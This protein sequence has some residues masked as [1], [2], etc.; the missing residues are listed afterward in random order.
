MDEEW[1]DVPQFEGMYAVSSRGR[2]RSLPRHSGARPSPV[3]ERLL[4]LSPGPTGYLRV[5]LRRENRSFTVKVH[6]LVL[7][8]FVGPRPDGMEGLHGNGDELDNRLEN[9]RWGT[10]SENMRDQVRHG[11]HVQARKT[12]CPKGHP[13]TKRNAA[14]SR[15]CMDCRRE[16][17]RD[18]YARTRGQLRS[19]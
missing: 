2:V 13:Y 11:T 3:G 14:G 12:T 16:Q 17:Y 19:S 18:Y 1:R 5:I 7:M 6:H 9:L 15:I 4:K 8:A 10:K